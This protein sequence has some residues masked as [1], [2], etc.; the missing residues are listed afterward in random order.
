MPPTT[1][2][3]SRSQRAVP[4]PL[5][6]PQVR[7]KATT[8]AKAP[9]VK[10]PKT[11]TKATKPKATA[12]ATPTKA[13]QTRANNHLL[14]SEF[15]TMEAPLP[16]SALGDLSNDILP[17]FSK[18][19]FPDLS[20][21]IYDEV[22]APAARLASR[23]LL[24][25]SLHTMLRTIVAHEPVIAIGE[26][27]TNGKPLHRY[28][29]NSRPIT[30][31]DIALIKTHL[32]ELAQFVNF[33][34]SIDADLP[35]AAGHTDP[36]QAKDESPTEIVST[37]HL[38]GLRSRVKY[39]PKLLALLTKYTTSLRRTKDYPIL[40]AW[41]FHFAVQLAH[42]AC[43]ALVFAKD[44]RRPAFDV[45]PF[46][47]G[48]KV[49]ETGFSVEEALFGGV[50]S[51]EWDR[52]KPNARG[53]FRK[54]F[55]AEGKVSMFVG[56]PVVWDWPA[57]WLVNEYLASGCA[58]WM[59]QADK[60]RLAKQDV[61]WRVPLAD[62][63]RFFSDE[64]W[65]QENPVVRLER[66]VGFAFTSGDAGE[67]FAHIIPKKNLERCVPEGYELSKHKAIVRTE[68]LER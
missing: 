52:Q 2:S 53:V 27:D 21:K 1:K 9:K 35:W 55:K 60:A 15:V 37:T 40:L 10:F 49:A 4:Y 65:V 17:L 29:A 50:V 64:F 54:H 48:K 42:E 19:N 24:H 28:P 58:L 45:E 67:R 36:I 32:T 13:Q 7:A 34:S 62:L 16:A 26:N 43:H 38:D 51:F 41:R 5:E 44:G 63:A 25:P 46:F 61:A 8:G 11:T 6:K 12:T 68:L 31:N 47:P 23:L 57:T 30:D 3:A 33:E 14:A 22:I 18:A 20:A 56:I 39:C 66:K 59:R